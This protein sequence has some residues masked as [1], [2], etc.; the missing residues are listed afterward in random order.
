[1]L[2]DILDPVTLQKLQTLKF[3]RKFANCETALGF[4]PDCL[5]LTR[6]SRQQLLE[7]EWKSFVVTWDL[8][9]GGVISTIERSLGEPYAGKA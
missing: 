4:S 5:M 8:Q 1:M 2:V 7:E 6:F 9:T 3:E